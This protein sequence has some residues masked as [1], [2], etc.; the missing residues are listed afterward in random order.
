MKR[1]SESIVAIAAVFAILAPSIPMCITVAASPAWA[2]PIDPISQV[3]AS[4][5]PAPG[6]STSASREP[7][8]VTWSDRGAIQYLG[9]PDGQVFSAPAADPA[10]PGETARSFLDAHRDLL[11][12]SSSAVGF[13]ILR[14]KARGERRYVR[15]Q[16]TYA[17]VPVFGARANVQLDATGGIEAVF[18]DLATETRELDEGRIPTSPSIPAAEATSLATARGS[19][20]APGAS[21]DTKPP[22][23]WWFDPAVIGAEGR[24]RLVWIVDVGVPSGASFRLLLDAHDGSIVREYPLGLSAL[25]RQVYDAN[26]TGNQFAS[27]VRD[28]GDPP[29]GIFDADVAYDY[30]GHTHSFYQTRHGRDGVD[31]AGAQIHASVRYCPASNCPYHNAYWDLFYDLMVF[32]EGWAADDVLAHEFTHGVTDYESN[33]I[34]ENASGAIN[35]SFS[36]VWGEFVDLTNGSGIDDPS[37]RWFLGE[38]LALATIRNM[39][40]PPAFE[41]PDRLGSPYYVPHEQNPADWNDYGGVHTNS[42]VNNKLCYLMTDGGTFNGETV[43]GMGIDA[44]ADL[45]Y[46]ATTNLLGPGAGWVDLFNALRQGAINLGWSQANRDNVYRAC[47]AVEIA[48]LYVRGSSNCTTQTGVWACTPGTSGPYRTVA[49]GVNGAF[50][51]ATVI[52]EGGNYAE[53]LTLSKRL[54]ITAIGGAARIGQ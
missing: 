3:M 13:T 33:L 39:A 35:E 51:G 44:V 6:R 42:G 12:V 20:K 5:R 21:V 36:D 2:Q 19:A 46:E 7:P 48:Q 25:D 8:R 18:A 4:L 38:D 17:G 45:Y 14:E 16:Q 15:L 30:T 11:G 24:V 43:S 1:G 26:H 10:R 23:L 47:I 32:G 41:D 52:V 27:L 34:Y 29:C 9:A 37:V 31:D 22:E 40:N 49:N 54:R 28:E 50:T 53:N